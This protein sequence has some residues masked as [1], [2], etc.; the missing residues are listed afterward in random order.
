M[1]TISHLNRLR[2]AGRYRAGVLTAAIAAH[3]GDFG[4]RFH[5]GRGGFLLTVRHYEGFPLVMLENRR[6]IEWKTAHNSLLRGINLIPLN[7]KQIKDVVPLQIH[8]HG[9]KGSAV[10]PLKMVDKSTSP[11]QTHFRPVFCDL[12]VQRGLHFPE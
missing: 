1:E 5:P 9:A 12:A 8:Q 7:S 4:M 11:P 10:L 2:S 6:G 3:M